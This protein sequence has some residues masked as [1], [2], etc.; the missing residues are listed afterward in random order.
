MVVPFVASKFPLAIISLEF[1]VSLTTAFLASKFPLAVISLTVISPV[2]STFAAV[3]FSVTSAFAAVNLPL[4]L[5]SPVTFNLLVVSASPP[6]P[7]LPSVTFI[8]DISS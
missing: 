5:V 3:I 6:I 1:I 8:W 4:T 2:T 7:I